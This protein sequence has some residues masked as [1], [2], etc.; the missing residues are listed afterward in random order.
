MSKSLQHIPANVSVML[1]ANIVIYAL[2]PQVKQHES[3]KRLLERS[4]RGEIHLHLVVN[5]V[6]DI[7]HRAM[8]LET[9]AQASLQK[10]REA[11]I[12]LKQNPQAVTSLTRYKNILSDLKQARIN[13][14]PLTYRDL[15][16]SKQFRYE[17]GLMT[18]DSLIVAVMKREKIQYLATNDSDFARIPRLAVRKPV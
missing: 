7:I 8:I 1:D 11:V 6:A 5:T 12:Y 3:C 16:N 18:N 15:H 13:I 4:A 10:S 14:L 2:F 9:M 17:Y